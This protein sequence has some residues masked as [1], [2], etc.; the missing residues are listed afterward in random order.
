MAFKGDEFYQLSRH[1]RGEQRQASETPRPELYKSF[2]AA[3]RFTLPK[4]TTSGGP[5]I[6]ATLQDR[7][8]MRAYGEEP[9][10][11]ATLS[12]LLWACTGRTFAH[13]TESRQFRTAPSAGAT[14]PYDTYLIVNNV[15]GLAP[16][17]Y[18]YDVRNHELELLAEGSLGPEAQNACLGQKTCATASVV[19]AWAATVERTTWRYAER[20]YRYMLI[21]AGHL[22][23]NLHLAATALSLGCCAIGAFY[24]EEVNRLFAVDG[25]NEV[26][27]YLSTVGT[28]AAQA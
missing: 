18:H 11:L 10:S 26:I 6:W 2:P 7:H 23:E 28:L 1:V 27:L 4:P 20:G 17:R 12:Q 24:D 3:K 8:S 19:F 14:F 5:G 16:G 13:D 9:M 15:D 21:D 25:V 22:Q